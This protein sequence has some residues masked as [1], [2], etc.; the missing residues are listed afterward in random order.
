MRRLVEAAELADVDL[1]AAVDERLPLVDHLGLEARAVPGPALV[2]LQRPGRRV[3]GLELVTRHPGRGVVAHRLRLVAARAL[4]EPEVRDAGHRHLADVEA[5]G[6]DE[7]SRIDLA[8]AGDERAH[9]LLVTLLEV[10]LVRP[11]LRRLVD[12]VEAELPAGDALVAPCEGLPVEDGRVERPLAIRLLSREEVGRL[13]LAAVD[14]VAGDAVE[15]D[16]DVDPVLFAQLDRT[17]DLLQRLF[18]DLRPV[19]AAA[20]RPVREWQAREVEAPLRDRGEVEL[21]EGGAVV[22][23]AGPAE[24]ALEIEATPARDAPGRDVVLG[25]RQGRRARRRGSAED[26]HLL[27][28]LPSLQG[29][30][31]RTRNSGRGPADY[32]PPQPR[33][34]PAVRRRSASRHESHRWTPK[35]RRMIA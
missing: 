3:H 14:A 1:H 15:V 19:V 5:V 34:R 4:H 30:P 21:V 26:R 35:K 31:S 22:R 25:R 23:V 29:S 10:A 27:D 9:D 8:D 2:V 24:P 11:H 12:Q 16:V 32:G 7:T 13:Q 18:A 20:P 6:E 17:V 28:E 33:S